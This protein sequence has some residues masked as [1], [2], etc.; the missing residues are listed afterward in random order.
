MSCKQKQFEFL[1]KLQE[2]RANDIENLFTDKINFYKAQL[3]CQSL[4]L[5]LFREAIDAIKSENSI[6]T[7]I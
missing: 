7:S 4:E 3:A 2:E 6:L 1:S 5:K